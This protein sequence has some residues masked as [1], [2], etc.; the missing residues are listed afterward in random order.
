MAFTQKCWKVEAS[1]ES[2]SQQS[3]HGRKQLQRDLDIFFLGRMCQLAEFLCYRDLVDKEAA[4][5]ET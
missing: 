2:L 4:T 1:S 5:G 3:A